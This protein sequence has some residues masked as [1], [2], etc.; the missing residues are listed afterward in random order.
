MTN[1]TISGRRALRVAHV[2]AFTLI[3]AAPARVP[4]QRLI[5]FTPNTRTAWTMDKWQPAMILAHRFEL[6]EGGDE[7]IS[8][9]T[10][11]FGMAVT[12]RIALG[13]DFTSNSEV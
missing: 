2:A 10:M 8:V 4:A 5:D 13:L 6:V 9:P 12:G 11:T 7:L 1:D 3:A